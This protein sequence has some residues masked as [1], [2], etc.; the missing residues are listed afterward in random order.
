MVYKLSIIVPIHNA[1]RYINR[2]LESLGEIPINVEVVLVNNRSTDRSDEIAR[3]YCYRHPTSRVIEENRPG[4]SYARNSG[5]KHATGEYVWFVD[6]D[7]VIHNNAIFKILDIITKEK[8][9]LLVFD[10]RSVD[11]T[12]SV[13]DDTTFTGFGE[14]V[15]KNKLV[16][17]MLTSPNDAIGGFPHN[18]VFSRELI[19]KNTFP[20]F[21]YAE[22]L[23]FFVPVLLR[24]NTVYRLHQVLYDYY[25]YP[26]SL[27]HSI[28]MP[29]LIDYYHVIDG[30]EGKMRA[31]GVAATMEVNGYVIE[32][33]LSIY[34]QCISFPQGSE[35][36]R[37]IRQN[38]K[39]Y[40]T[41]TIFYLIRRS[42]KVAFKF[43]LFKLQILASLTRIRNVLS[44]FKDRVS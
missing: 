39:D 36:C 13:P 19:G 23:A 16:H 2:T 29:K 6:A 3:D 18:K 5:L 1:E 20:N 32:H 33:K 21:Q 38:M 24:S 10:Y 43:L 30:I 17:E 11:A 40:Q 26:D 35:L 44:M 42:K 9:D 12:L 15:S 28:S 25:Q 37:T 8:P 31:S 27:A 14:L 7:D 41:I 34:S 4:A 22:D